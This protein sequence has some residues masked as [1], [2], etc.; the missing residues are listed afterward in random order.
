M[1]MML[2]M[3]IDFSFNWPSLFSVSKW[4]RA[5]AHK[6]CLY[7]ICLHLGLL[8]V[9]DNLLTS[10]SLLKIGQTARA[11]LIPFLGQIPVKTGSKICP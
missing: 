3:I 7:I 1:A 9:A 4:Q 5:A 2:Q 10:F 6:G 8:L 11:T